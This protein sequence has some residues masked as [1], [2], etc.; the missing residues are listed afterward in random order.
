MKLARG[1]SGELPPYPASKEQLE[2]VLGE[3]HQPKR[4]G[5]A[6]HPRWLT[7]PERGLYTG[8]A[9]VGATG[10][11]KT[12]GCMH[13][14]A[15][16]IL[17]FACHDPAKRIGGLVLEVKGD[18][19]QKVRQIMKKHGRCTD[20]IELNLESRYRYNPLHNELEAYA[21][22]YGIA[23]LLNNLYGHGKEP[24]WQQAYTNMVK[25]IILLHKVLYGYATL[26]DVYECAINP[27]LMEKRLEEGRRIYGGSHYAIIRMDAWVTH[28]KALK[29]LGFEMDSAATR[30]RAVL[31]KAAEDFLRKNVIPYE[32]E[33]ADS[34]S[35]DKREQYEAVRR[36]FYHDW[37][38]IEPKLRTSV[39]EGIS[40]F[41]SLFDDN[42]AVKRV[43]CPP[44]ECY[45][46]DKNADHRY[47][48]PL[49]PFAE[50]IEKGIVCALNFP[51]ASNPGMA[52]TVGTLMKLDFERAVLMRIPEMESHRD[53]HHR[54]VL[55]LCD[56]YHSFAR[57][58]ASRSWQARASVHSGRPFPA[59]P[60]AR[61]CK[62]SGQ[63]YS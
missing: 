6:A 44:K 57:P 45:D 61:C 50:L 62:P 7:I 60:G 37:Q 31:T 42:P 8:I 21:L 12:S 33:T 18:F 51:F 2:L 43:F 38:R 36:W 48:I 29:E 27:D 20:F 32:I 22:A 39:V 49:P 40:V 3:I 63:R 4:P 25:F 28:G 55:F 47:G 15:D 59:N 30:L 17:S 9:V 16:Q 13:P 54:Q 19:C 26:F 53:K 5:P 14:F 58:N 10:S 41:L 34:K 35:S 46:K 24:F 23:S 1:V 56:E 52:R 11:G